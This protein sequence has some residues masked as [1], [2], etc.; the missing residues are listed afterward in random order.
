MIK[1]WLYEEAQA[2]PQDTT[3]LPPAP[4]PFL[5]FL[6]T[7]VWR[8]RRPP[9]ETY[10]VGPSAATFQINEYTFSVESS[11]DIGS[12][13]DT[14]NLESSASV[15]GGNGTIALYDIISELLDEAR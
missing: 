2:P 3:V 12:Q 4:V 14:N 10:G 7:Y 9:H 6:E 13:L 5:P 8:K 15:R 11:V 1:K